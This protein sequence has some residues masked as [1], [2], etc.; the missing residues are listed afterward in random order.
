MVSSFI[1]I[2]PARDGQYQCHILLKWINFS[3]TSSIQFLIKRGIVNSA[4]KEYK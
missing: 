2:N 1:G 3:N 4:V